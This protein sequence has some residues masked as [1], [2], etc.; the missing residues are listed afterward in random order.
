MNVSP[1]LIG[2]I[3]EAVFF[4]ILT[5]SK[6]DYKM[7]SP[8]LLHWFNQ[9]TDILLDGIN[10]LSIADSMID[11]FQAF[12]TVLGFTVSGSIFKDFKVFDY[13]LYR[14]VHNVIMH[15]YDTLSSIHITQIYCKHLWSADHKICVVIMF[16]TKDKC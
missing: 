16:F 7:L 4:Y 1:K 6:F 5:R 9:R 15:F 10:D 11:C 3:I 13:L 14:N 12:W 2:N 8:L